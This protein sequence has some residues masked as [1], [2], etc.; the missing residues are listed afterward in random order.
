MTLAKATS[1]LNS[2]VTRSMD[3]QYFCHRPATKA[4]FFVLSNLFQFH[5]FIIS[6]TGSLWHQTIEMNWW[7]VIYFCDFYYFWRVTWLFAVVHQP[8]SEGWN[9]QIGE[10]KLENKCLEF[11]LLDKNVGRKCLVQ[12][13]NESI[14]VYLLFSGLFAQCYQIWWVNTK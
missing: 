4:N 5:F 9:T 13:R 12:F 14:F 2:N 7:F 11:W 8:I 6:G 1:L 10:S 3:G